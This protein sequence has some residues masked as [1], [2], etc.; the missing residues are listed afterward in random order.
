M[1]TGYKISPILQTTADRVKSSISGPVTASPTNQVTYLISDME[2]DVQHEREVTMI[3]LS[4]SI[5]CVLVD[6]VGSKV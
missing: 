6:D 2:T 1:S 5:Q 4:R 3:D